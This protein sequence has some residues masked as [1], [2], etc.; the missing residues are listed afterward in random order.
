MKKKSMCCSLG[1]TSCGNEAASP[2]V[3]PFNSEINNDDTECR[4][5]EDCEASCAD[6]I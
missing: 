5:C 2:H 3:C 4:C 1:S 6:E